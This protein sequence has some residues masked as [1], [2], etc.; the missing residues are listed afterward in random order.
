MKKIWD[1]IKNNPNR[2]MFIVPIIL[3]A[4]V[5]ISH[6][7]SWY[8][9]MNPYNWAIYLSIAIE[10]GAMTALVAATNKIKGGVWVMFGLVT[11]I[12]MI[13]NIFFSYKEIDATGD[14]FK[15][16]M[17][18]TAPIWE[19]L[20][21]D[22]NDV[23]VHKRWLAFLGGGLLPIISLTS[24]HFFIKYEDPEKNKT[25]LNEDK[26]DEE[27]TIDINNIQVGSMNTN[28]NLKDAIENIKDQNLKVNPKNIKEVIENVDL[29]EIKV[30]KVNLK[31]IRENIDNDETKVNQNTSR[32]KNEVLN[33]NVQ[34]NT[35][36]NNDEIKTNIINENNI[37][38]VNNSLTDNYVNSNEETQI[39]N[40]ENQL[41]EPPQ[42]TENTTIFNNPTNVGSKIDVTIETNSEENLVQETSNEMIET[43]Q[44][45]VE[46]IT[47]TTTIEG[48]RVLTYTK[49]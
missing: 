43:P 33:D 38:Q 10:I 34:Q 41:S 14:L 27:N 25:K 44:N 20:G 36:I 1:W 9:I 13:G 35:T 26:T 18:L 6:V 12:Q 46:E 28:V 49:K 15:S 23:V 21:S 42:V 48:K 5:S 8:D 17:E 16:W 40:N 4:I 47:T 3:V 2:T 31:N 30:D 45:V 22:I 24:L 37:E 19:L 7:V 39:I 29:N 11:F 32:V